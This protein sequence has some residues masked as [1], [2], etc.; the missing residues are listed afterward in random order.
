MSYHLLSPL[1][2]RKREAAA[3]AA[4]V[5]TAVV[6]GSWFAANAVAS[7][8]AAIQR[9]EPLKTLCRPPVTEGAMTV[10]AF[11]DGKSVCWRWKE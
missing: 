8:E 11:I 6:V 7:S 2:L 5:C 3:F 4:G 9:D 10:W 1:S